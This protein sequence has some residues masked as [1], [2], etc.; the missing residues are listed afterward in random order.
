MRA[1][2]KAKS[3]PDIK[4]PCEHV[5]S[6]KMPGYF[7]CCIFRW[8][9]PRE[10]FKWSLLCDAAPKLAKAH[11]EVPNVL[12]QILG[13]KMKLSFRTST[14]SDGQLD[15][16]STSMLPPDFE[17]AITDCIAPLTL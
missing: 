6:L 1:Y 4:N 3:D 10:N 2:E 7:R 16:S 17:N 9:K 8:K 14:G 11:K 12:R 15:S 5:A 13:K